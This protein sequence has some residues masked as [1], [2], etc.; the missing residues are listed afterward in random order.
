MV[1]ASLLNVEKVVKPPHNPTTSKS[2][3]SGDRL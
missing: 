3:K 1:R 2:R